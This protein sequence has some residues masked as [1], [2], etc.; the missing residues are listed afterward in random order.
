VIL[1][2][3]EV[4]NRR[5]ILPDGHS[6]QLMVLPPLNTMTPELLKKVSQLV[7]EGATILGSPP[8]RSPSMRNYP[9]CDAEV[10]EIANKLWEGCDGEKVKTKTFGK[11]TVLRGLNIE[12]AFYNL[13]IS[14]D[15][16]IPDDVHV[17]WIH[18]AV[19]QSHIYFL[20][21]QSDSLI[22]FSATFRVDQKQPELWDAVSG[23]TK[24]LHDYSVEHGLT[25]IPLTFNPGQSY[26][27]IF[28][29]PPDHSSGAENYTRFSTYFNVTGP[30][31]VFFDSTMRGPSEPV[32]LQELKDW[33]SYPDE[34]VRYYSGLATYQTEFNLDSI[35]A[36]DLFL[37]LGDVRVIAKI[38]LNEAD[39]G[40]VWT[41]PWEV[42]ITDAVRI[43]N[44]E[45]RIEV[46]NTWVNRLVKDS[47]LPEHDR[48]TWTAINPYRIHDNLQKSGLVGPVR[49]II[50]DPNHYFTR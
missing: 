46:I 47:D 48:L 24:I 29:K 31:E 10:L 18:Y 40:G 8:V 32:I 26:F 44:N 39:L 22:Q 33:S 34:R 9:Q 21:N 4:E 3:M 11:G 6:Y 28:S 13:D 43:G 38:T 16:D 30:W 50:P 25:T 37:S 17:E 15:L 1:N 49:I 41:A 7:T 19:D 2:H 12:E 36:K 5:L 14:P 27:V 35:P 23:K 42:E 20:T 45:L